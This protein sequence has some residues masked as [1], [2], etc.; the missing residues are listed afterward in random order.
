MLTAFASAR[1]RLETSGETAVDDEFGA[2]DVATGV[3]R[4]EDRQPRQLARLASTAQHCPLADR[5]PELLAECRGHVSE[6]RP[7]ENGVGSD[8]VWT[9]FE[10]Q[11]PDHRAGG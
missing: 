8:P 5:A 11:A 7:R 10:S 9:E 1:Q 6:E 4:Q 2:R 3:A